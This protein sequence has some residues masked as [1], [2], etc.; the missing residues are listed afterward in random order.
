MTEPQ[1]RIWNDRL[2]WIAAD[3]TIEREAGNKKEP[4]MTV[5][6]FCRRFTYRKGLP[7]LFGR[8]IRESAA[9]DC[10]SFA[11][12][13]LLILEG[14][15]LGAVKAQITGKAKLVRVKSPV[16][17]T[18]PMHVALWHRDYG[19]IDSTRR[20]WRDG[21]EPHRK[22]WPLWCEKAALAFAMWQAWE[23]RGLLEYLLG[24]LQ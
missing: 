14:G 13:V 9:G 7:S 6:E 17:G 4:P 15:F 10:G 24:A 8:D 18:I 5:D 19:W 2:G 1:E 11:W 12:T 21:P 23:N 22:R 16:N 20:E 3:G